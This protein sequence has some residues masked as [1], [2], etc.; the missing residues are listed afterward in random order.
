MTPRPDNNAAEQ[1]RIDRAKRETSSVAENQQ[2]VEALARQFHEMYERLAPEYGYETRP[3]SAVPWE[4]VPENNRALMQAVVAEVLR[5]IRVE[6]S[7][8]A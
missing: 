5:Q 3:E 1:W 2:T 7:D 6:D 4:D 8:D